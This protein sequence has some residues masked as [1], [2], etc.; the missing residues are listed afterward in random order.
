MTKLFAA[1]ALVTLIIGGEALAMPSVQS[2]RVLRPAAQTGHLGPVHGRR[3]H[4][5]VMEISSFSYGVQT[6]LDNT[7]G[8]AA[9]KRGHRPVFREITSGHSTGK[10]QH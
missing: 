2:N 3:R 1:A 9:G 4:S 5:E 8:H 7:S 6:P 10:R